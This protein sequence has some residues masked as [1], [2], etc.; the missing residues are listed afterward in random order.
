MIVWNAVWTIS[1]TGLRFASPGM[2]PSQAQEP[3]ATRICDFFR[4][5]FAICSFSSLRI[6][7]LKSVSRIEPSCMASTSLYFASIATGQKTTSKLASTSR[8]FSCVLRTAISQPPQEAAQY[9]A[10]LGLSFVVMQAPP[11]RDHGRWTMDGHGPS[12]TVHYPVFPNSAAPA[13]GSPPRTGWFHWQS[14][15]PRRRWPKRA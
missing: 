13:C 8:I 9:M 1:P 3:N 6:P 10:N 2:Q 15:L 5:S 12:S 14:V 4:N 11:L 7:P